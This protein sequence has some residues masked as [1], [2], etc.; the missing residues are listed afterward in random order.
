MIALHDTDNAVTNDESRPSV[1]CMEDTCL[2]GSASRIVS[3]AHFYLNSGIGLN[4]ISHK[5]I[6]PPSPR[7]LQLVG[8]LANDPVATL[9]SISNLDFNLLTT[10]ITFLELL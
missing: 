7:C 6:S 2:E 1:Q 3:V 4:S 10:V 8:T 9:V 5:S